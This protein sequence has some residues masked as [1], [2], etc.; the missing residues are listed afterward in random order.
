CRRRRVERDRA[1]MGRL[2][3]RRCDTRKISR[4]END[5]S[6]R[7]QIQESRYAHRIAVVEQYWLRESSG[8][9]ENRDFVPNEKRGS[10]KRAAEFRFDNMPAVDSIESRNELT[11]LVR[12]GTAKKIN[13]FDVHALLLR[14]RAAQLVDVN[15][16]GLGQRT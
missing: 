13:E 15:R 16:R 8:I 7:D 2:G 4:E 12:F 11:L 3:N 9:V 14:A 1:R 5:L 6:R 10:T